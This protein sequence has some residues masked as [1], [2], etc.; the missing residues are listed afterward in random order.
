MIIHRHHYAP[1]QA[2]REE[3]RAR[4]AEIRAA[5]EQHREQKKR[6]LAFSVMLAEIQRPRVMRDLVERA[7]AGAVEHFLEQRFAKADSRR[8]LADPAPITGF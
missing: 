7:V 8:F 4:A 1:T 3:L 5:L 2:Q 6:E